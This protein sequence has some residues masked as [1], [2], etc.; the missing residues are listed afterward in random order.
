MTKI[1]PIAMYQSSHSD[2]LSWYYQARHFPCRHNSL[3]NNRGMVS[4][5]SITAYSRLPQAHTPRHAQ[6]ETVFQKGKANI[7]TGVHFAPANGKIC[8]TPPTTWLQMVRDWSGGTERARE[9]RVS[10]HCPLFTCTCQVRT[11]SEQAHWP[12]LCHQPCKSTLSR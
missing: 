3:H 6:G 10:I 5:G 12:A 2:R 11:L 7:H 8:K 1:D 9:S 4:A